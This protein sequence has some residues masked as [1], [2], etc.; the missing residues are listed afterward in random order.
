M[1]N[2]TTYLGNLHEEKFEFRLELVRIATVVVYAFGIGFPIALGLLLK[3]FKA[4]LSPFKVIIP[5]YGRYYAFTV[6]H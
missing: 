4:K 3:F 6:T 5:I 2:L 1:G